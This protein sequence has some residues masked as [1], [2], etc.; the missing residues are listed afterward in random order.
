MMNKISEK[1]KIL[2]RVISL[3]DQFERRAKSTSELKKIDADWKFIDA[4]D[5]RLKGDYPA[6]YNQK[7]R[8]K[9]YGRSMSMGEICCFMSHQIAWRGNPPAN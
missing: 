3:A 4:I 6:E 8:L 7:N 9:Y 2:C 5:G 1:Q